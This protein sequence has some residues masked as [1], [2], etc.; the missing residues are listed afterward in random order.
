MAVCSGY[1]NHD[2]VSDVNDDEIVTY[3]AQCGKLDTT[4]LAPDDDYDDPKQDW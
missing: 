2:W 1:S 4:D 3:C